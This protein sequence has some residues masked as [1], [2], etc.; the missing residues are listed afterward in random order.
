MTGWLAAI[1]LPPPELLCGFLQ[2]S[3]VG[4]FLRGYHT[5]VT[6]LMV[7]LYV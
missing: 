7:Y 5:L 2:P 6:V 1:L 3:N 4:R